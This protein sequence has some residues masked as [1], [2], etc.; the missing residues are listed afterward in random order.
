MYNAKPVNYKENGP[1]DKVVG[2]LNLNQGGLDSTPKRSEQSGST[3]N[4]IS[5]NEN[6]ANQSVMSKGK[7]TCR[8]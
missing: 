1:N 2:K 7:V 8:D 4:S 6:A 5:M 3:R